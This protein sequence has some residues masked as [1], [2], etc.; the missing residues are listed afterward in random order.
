M[1]KVLK[2]IYGKV[3][4]LSA[5]K[6]STSSL[7]S[8]LRYCKDIANL[9][10][11]ELWEWSTISIKN[12]SINLQ[13]TFM[14]VCMQQIKFIIHFFLKILQRNIKLVILGNWGI[15]RHSENDSINLKKSA[16]CKQKTNFILSIF[17]EILQRYCKFVILGTLGK[18]AYKPKMI[19]APCR[20]LSY[21]SVG[22]HFHPPCFSR[23]NTKICKL[24]ILGT[25]GMPGCALPKW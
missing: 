19:L 25:L 21:L 8:F 24:P 5:C 4:C 17:L 9:L 2:S 22:K 20:K 15:P 7:T 16:F 12:H 6:S 18:P 3:W 10:F 14:L 13:E 23:D 11:S 1:L